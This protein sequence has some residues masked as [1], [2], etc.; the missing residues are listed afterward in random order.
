MQNQNVFEPAFDRSRASRFTIASM[1]ACCFAL[2]AA[3]GSH[4]ADGA[5]TGA[6]GNGGSSTGEGASSAITASTVAAATGSGGAVAASST[7]GSGTNAA[8]S[9]ASGGSKPGLIGC[10]DW[11]NGGVTQALAS[12]AVVQIFGPSNAAFATWNGSGTSYT[13]CWTNG[14]TDYLTLAANGDLS[15]TNNIGNTTSGTATSCPT[16]SDPIVGCYAWFNGGVTQV[17]ASGGVVQTWQS[18]TPAFAT[19]TQSNGT[20]TLAWT[21]GYTDTL[22]LDQNG[23]LSGT[24]NIGNTTSGTPVDCATAPND[25]A[26]CSTNT[27]STSTGS[28]SMCTGTP[29]SCGSHASVGACDDS[30]CAW[31]SACTGSPLSCDGFFSESEC[32]DQHCNWDSLGD[33]CYGSRVCDMFSSFDCASIEGCQWTSSCTGEPA[34]CSSHDGANPYV[35]TEAGCQSN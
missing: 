28:G 20:Y 13:F 6:A 30:G 1:V 5:G 35:C 22:T 16:S 9:A 3:C 11:F 25:G 27:S 23:A 12:G 29:A 31:T 33:G 26:V 24:N 21:N 10:Y 17:L 14:F 34:P 19:W 32:E 18:G 2:V 4:G 15:G 8:S 7:S